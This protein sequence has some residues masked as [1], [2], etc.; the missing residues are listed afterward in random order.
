MQ[1]RTIL[2]WRAFHLSIVLFPLPFWDASL[3]VMVDSKV[4]RRNY[5][6]V[7]ISE[8]LFSAFLD[9][10]YFQMH[11]ENVW[12]VQ[13]VPKKR[14]AICWNWHLVT[15]PFSCYFQVKFSVWT[16]QECSETGCN[17]KDSFAISWDLKRL[18]QSHL[19]SSHAPNDFIRLEW[20]QQLPS[21]TKSF[22]V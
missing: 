17:F 4:K 13:L 10:S 18:F 9:G 19:K 8:L 12:L 1:R 22:R 7:N 5:F 6:K 14:N 3:S 15:I 21:F 2:N 20:M 16:Y 11:C